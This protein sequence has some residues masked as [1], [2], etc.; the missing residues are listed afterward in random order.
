MS[1]PTDTETGELP[2]FTFNIPP[3]FHEVPLTASPEDRGDRLRG[4][5]EGL[6]GAEGEDE[7]ALADSAAALARVMDQLLEQDVVHASF[8]VAPI[9][10][11]PSAVSLT[12]AARPAE[13]TDPGVAAEAIAWMLAEQEPDE[14]HVQRLRLPCGPAAAVTERRRLPLP[15]DSSDA[16]RL[17]LDLG[18]MQVHVP[19]P[20]GWLLVFTLH[21]PVLADWEV[22]AHLLGGVVNSLSLSEIASGAVT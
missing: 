8:G 15:G 16:E 5:I 9:D 12:V 21:T 2:R 18:Q 4:F 13:S 10:G 22:Y 7:R 11:N 6:P 17:A 3:D 20:G 14:R 1:E 19:A